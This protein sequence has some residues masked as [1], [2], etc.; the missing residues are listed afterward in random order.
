MTTLILADAQAFADLATL[1]S[2]ARTADPDGAIRLQAGG[3]TL[4]AYVR[5]LPGQGLMSEGAAIGM[6]VMA[7][8]EPAELD[9]V[10][11]L[12]GLEDRFA[13]DPRGPALPVPPATTSAAWASVSP[14]RTGWERVGILHA[15]DLEHAARD[16]IREIAEGTTRA[17]GGHAVAAL[18]RSVWNRLTATTPPIRAGGA[19]AAYALGFIA[20]GQQCQVFAHG[21]WTRLST[22]LGHVLIR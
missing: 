11:P 13:R 5:A 16:G 22:P 20:P 3:A 4:A 6:R 17:A 9:V 15:A 10:T 7:L 21:R 8:R 1:V 12:A 14:P 2:R 18:R 19:F